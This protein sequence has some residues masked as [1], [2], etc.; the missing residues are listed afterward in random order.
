MVCIYCGAP[1]AVT[2]SRKQRRSNSIWRRRKCVS[3][4]SI[5]T[6]EEHTGLS[7]SLMVEDKDGTL[8]PF[9]RDQLFISLYESCKHRP[10]AL[11]DAT[12]LTQLVIRNLIQDQRHTA[13]LTRNSIV[14]ACQTVLLRFDQPAATMY[15]AYHPL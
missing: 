6:T 7:Q 14:Q 11:P 4:L 10:S 2:N 12:S 3:C 1:T 15:Q 5:F 9:R 8:V 13:L